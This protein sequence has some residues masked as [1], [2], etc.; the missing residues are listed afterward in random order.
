MFANT[1][2]RIAI[3]KNILI[4]CLMLCSFTIFAQKTKT[5]EI[6][7]RLSYSEYIDAIYVYNSENQVDKIEIRLACQNSKYSH[8]S[9]LINIYYGTPAG[10]YKFLN[11]LEVF[12][13]ENESG[14]TDYVQNH[15]ISVKEFSGE[16]G[17]WVYEKK[18]N[19]F[20]GLTMKDIDKFKT[21]FI[22]WCQKN[23]VAYE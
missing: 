10:F 7:K 22:D 3:M 2:Q 1:N 14:V 18:G 17:L 11:E 9:D 8:M 15:K 23:N 12:F 4:I 5:V 20:H 6:L 19:G 16:K 13:K 21:K